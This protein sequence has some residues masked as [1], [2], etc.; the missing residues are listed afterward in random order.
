MSQG[1]RRPQSQAVL[2]AVAGVGPCP[3]R[4]LR[5]PP[6]RSADADVP[7]GSEGAGLREDTGYRSDGVS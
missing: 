4:E 3:R 2:R 7:E 6:R 1:D 5:A